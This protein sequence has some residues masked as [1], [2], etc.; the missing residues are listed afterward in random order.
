MKPPTFVHRARQADDDVSQIHIFFAQ[1]HANR[2]S[3]TMEF[4]KCCSLVVDNHL[5]TKIYVP[6]D[7]LALGSNF[8]LLNAENTQV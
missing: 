5:P 8:I 7:N 4:M 6:V 1:S 3:V 2:N